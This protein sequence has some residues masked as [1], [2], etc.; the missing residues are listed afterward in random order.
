ML[1][2]CTS[3][4]VGIKYKFLLIPNYSLCVHVYSWAH[5]FKTLLSNFAT[6]LPPD[7][8][9][10]L[11]LILQWILDVDRHAGS[12]RGHKEMSY[13]IEAFVAFSL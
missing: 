1:K 13:F 5:T 6:P 4:T 9:P 10:R 2:Y 12:I 7:L 3:E 11:H 8:Y